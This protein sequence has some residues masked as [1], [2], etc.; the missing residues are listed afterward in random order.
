[1]PLLALSFLGAASA[2]AGLT[3]EGSSTIADNIMPEMTKAF[4]A[5]AKIKFD[6]VGTLGSG[7]G[8]KAATDGTA[9]IGGMSRGLNNEEKKKKPYYQ[10]IGHDAIAVFVHSTNAL[11]DLSKEQIKGIFTGKIKNWKEVGGKDAKINVVTEVVTG[12]RA[13]LKEFKEMAL[14]GEA[15]KPTKQVDTA[16]DCVKAVA[17]DPNAITNASFSFK[18][19]D[20]VK[21]ISVNKVEANA[22]NIRSGNFPF[23][24]PLLLLTKD[25]PTGDVKQFFDFVLSTDGQ[26]IVAKKFVSAR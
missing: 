24:R 13:T 20:G 8:F 18:D 21:I 9:S 1:M 2:V 26:A 19:L 22:A 15:Y 10:V 7:K 23:S 12:D 3:Y 5:K 25:M 6:K 11:G 14:D 17:A 4:E 16:Q